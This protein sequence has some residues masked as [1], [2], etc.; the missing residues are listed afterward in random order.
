LNWPSGCI[1]RCDL[2]LQF[3]KYPFRH[4]NGLFCLGADS[5]SQ[6]KEDFE[7]KHRLPSEGISFEYVVNRVA[8]LLEIAAGQVLARGKDK[9]T[10]TARRI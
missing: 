10:V 7:G 3:W 2:N 8:E 4:P 9:E 6:A 5:Q 1:V